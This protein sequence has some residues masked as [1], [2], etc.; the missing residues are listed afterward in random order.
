M[1]PDAM[2]GAVRSESASP[3]HELL[4][5]GEDRRLTGATGGFVVNL[6]PI[7]PSSTRSK[8]SKMYSQERNP[9]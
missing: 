6:T 5:G 2:P 8:R 4:D 3:A 9:R 1:E 7:A